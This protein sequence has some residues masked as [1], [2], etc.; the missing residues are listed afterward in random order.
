MM[1]EEKKGVQFYNTTSIEIKLKIKAM[2][3]HLKDM[4]SISREVF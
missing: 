3:H 4:V 1:E 2:S